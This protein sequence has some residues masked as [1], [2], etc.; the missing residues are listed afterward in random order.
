MGVSINDPGNFPKRL[1]RR[2]DY[3][4][5]VENAVKL[6]SGIAIEAGK[7]FPPARMSSGSLGISGRGWAGEARAGE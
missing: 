3:Y 4:R 7:M 2:L 1:R 6:P 5:R